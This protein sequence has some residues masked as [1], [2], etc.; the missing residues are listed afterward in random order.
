MTYENNNKNELIPAKESP[1]VI[2]LWSMASLDETSENPNG[3]YWLIGLHY[4]LGITI[5]RMQDNLPDDHP[6]KSAPLPDIGEELVLK[7]IISELRQGLGNPQKIT[8]I[9]FSN[10]EF[11]NPVNFSNLIFPISVLFSNSK[12]HKKVEFNYTEFFIFAKFNGTCFFDTVQFIEARLS[13]T[14][15]QKTEFRNVVNFFN[16]TFTKIVDFTGAIFFNSA[17]FNNAKFQ[18]HIDFSEVHFKNVVA[19]FYSA[20]IN[21]SIVWDNDI[22]LW[23]EATD[24]TP[25][26]LRLNRNAYENLAY[27]MKKLDKYH[28]EHFFFRQEMRCRRQLAGN[29]ISRWAYGLYENISNYGYGVGRAIATWFVHILIGALILFAIRA[30]NRWNMSWEDFGC[31][32]GISLSNSHAFFFNGDRLEKCYKTFEYL[33]AFNVIWGVQTITGTLLIFLV[34]L[35][36][37]VRFRLK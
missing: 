2:F 30:F 18:R 31:S 8:Q 27:H 6:L 34:L 32:L 14:Y 28:D 10:L 35:T 4:L 37:R 19:N 26:G 17:L 24:M 15:F 29:F 36:L 33:P 22:K 11:K 3:W 20:E 13:T 16:A 12:F 25:R 23:P 5:K 7:Q 9:D 21:A 1:W